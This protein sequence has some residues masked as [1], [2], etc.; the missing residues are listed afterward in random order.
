MYL[1][2]NHLS[3]IIQNNSRMLMHVKICY[4]K[5][6]GLGLETITSIPK[7]TKIAYYMGKV[8]NT[9]EAKKHSKN[10]HIHFLTV[11]GTGCSIDGS[12][13]NFFDNHFPPF[14]QSF[15]VP[16]P[17]MSLT[18]FSHKYQKENCKMVISQE[19]RICSDGNWLD[20][21][22]YLVGT[23]DIEPFEEQIWNYRY[24]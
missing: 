4:N 19:S 17:L 22:V 10:K 2:S 23:E 15:Q 9:N 21:T 14:D 13:N 16:C 12:L 8:W 7:G 6:V 11:P 24:M 1:F 20:K 18:N 5:K 3:L